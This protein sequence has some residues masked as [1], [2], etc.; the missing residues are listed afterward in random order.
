MRTTLG[1]SFSV[2]FL[3]TGHC[4]NQVKY[5]LSP[6]SCLS[7]VT[8]TVSDLTTWR[9]A[10]ILRWHAYAL[11]DLTTMK[12]RSGPKDHFLVQPTKHYFIFNHLYRNLADLSCSLRSCLHLSDNKSPLIIKLRGL[13]LPL[14]QFQLLFQGLEWTLLLPQISF[15]SWFAI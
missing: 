1:T 4:E 10:Q 5:Y 2:P 9:T 12:N 8:H 14:Q 7:L 6:V 13:V 15:S 11:N 3:F